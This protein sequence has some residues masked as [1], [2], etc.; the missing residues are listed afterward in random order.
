MFFKKNSFFYKTKIVFTVKNSV[1]ERDH[2]Y[3]V[4]EGWKK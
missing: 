4:Y 1:L 3:Q 2:Y